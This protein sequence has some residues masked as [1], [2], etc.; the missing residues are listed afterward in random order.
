MRS[1]KEGEHII[2]LTVTDPAGASDV[3]RVNI[4]VLHQITNIAPVPVI[5]NEDLI[6]R[7][8]EIVTVDASH[9][10]DI[11]GTIVEWSFDWGDT[12]TPDVQKSGVGNHVYDKTGNYTVIVTVKDNS[13]ISNTTFVQVMIKDI[14]KPPPK[15]R[16]NYNTSVEEPIWFV[17]VF[18]I[19]MVLVFIAFVVARRSR[20]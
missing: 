12:S 11:D 18:V 3:A 2:T 16:P 20:Y 17:L 6:K 9:S 1:L 19:V 4:T 14:V 15:P 7:R 8:G 13:G 10:Y 5:S